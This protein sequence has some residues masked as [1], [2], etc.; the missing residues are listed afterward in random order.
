MVELGEYKTRE[1]ETGET[2][3][4]W[5]GKEKPKTEKRK[6]WVGN[7]NFSDATVDGNK[8]SELLNNKIAELEEQGYDIINISPVESG[9][10]KYQHD[11]LLNQTTSFLSKRKTYGGGWGYGYG[12]GYTSGYLILAN[13][14]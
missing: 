13:K 4:S 11:G 3:K 10:W 8:T 1:V 14:K 5:L 12:Y 6:E 2:T 9:N 7:G